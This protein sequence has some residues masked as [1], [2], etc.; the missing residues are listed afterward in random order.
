[1]TKKLDDMAELIGNTVGTIEA[2]SIVAGASLHEGMSEAVGIA[3]SST[4][5]K[6]LEKRTRPTRK[7]LTKKAEK[8]KKTAKKNTAKA[9]KKI[10]AAKKKAT[11]KTAKARKKIGAS[12]KKVAKKTAKATKKR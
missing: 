10:G 1:M 2:A 12:K 9:A 6:Q 3:G 7:S 5:A 8:S 11:K 4:V